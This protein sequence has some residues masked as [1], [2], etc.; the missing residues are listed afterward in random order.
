MIWRSVYFDAVKR[1][2]IFAPPSASVSKTMPITGLSPAMKPEEKTRV[3]SK[4]W[5]Q[6][7]R[8]QARLIAAVKKHPN[9]C[10]SPWARGNLS[11]TSGDFAGACELMGKDLIVTLFSPPEEKGQSIEQLAGT[12]FSRARIIFSGGLHAFRSVPAPP[13]SFAPCNQSEVGRRAAR[14]NFL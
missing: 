7:R 13:Q 10:N 14:R 5:E 11:R 1:R 4:L 6:P 9:C 12:S 8:H 2:R 3:F